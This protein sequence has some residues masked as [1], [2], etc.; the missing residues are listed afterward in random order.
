MDEGQLLDYKD[1]LREGLLKYTR[2]AFGKMPRIKSR[3]ILDIGCGSG[4]PTLELAR[5]SDGNI[6]AIDT[7]RSE[8]ERLLHKIEKAGLTSRIKVEERSMIAMD[9]REED[10][11]I[12]WA[13]GA[14][15]VIGFE[16]GLRDWRRFLKNEG[17]LVIHDEMGEL[18]EKRKMISKYEYE[19]IDHFILSEDIWRDEYFTPLKN[20]IINIRE[21][22]GDIQIDN[23]VLGEMER[24]VEFFEQDP[25]RNRSVFLIMK[26]VDRN[27]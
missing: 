5:L 27:V 21:I 26:K 10:F 1:S 23:P 22:S 8:L 7:N 4:I 16:K 24:E 12:I 25:K 19:L 6:T 9:F 2:K 11:D 18:T 15:N 3:S 17:F 13:E 14:I 20:K